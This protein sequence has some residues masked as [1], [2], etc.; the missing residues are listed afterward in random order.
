[1]AQKKRDSRKKHF[2]PQKK[3]PKMALSLRFPPA[4][5]GRFGVRFFRHNF[6]N[7]RAS[8]GGKITSYTPNSALKSRNL[9]LS[10]ERSP[11]PRRLNVQLVRI[12]SRRTVPSE[13]S[14]LRTKKTPMRGKVTGHQNRGPKC[15]WTRK[16]RERNHQ[17]NTATT[18]ARRKCVRRL[19]NN[20]KSRSRQLARKTKI[21]RTDFPDTTRQRVLGTSVVLR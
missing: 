1:M 6:G 14:A 4:G 20:K 3:N 10:T 17:H 13:T 18:T 19:L 12:P 11:F 8:R 2:G 9:S 16:R 5:P 21:T 7:R 15:T